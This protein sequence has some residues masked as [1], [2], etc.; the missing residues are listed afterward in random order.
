MSFVSFE[1]PIY[2]GE[3]VKIFPLIAS[4]V[5]ARDAARE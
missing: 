1:N 3:R 5:L 2:F 4:R